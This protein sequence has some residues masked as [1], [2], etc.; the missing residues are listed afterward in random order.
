MYLRGRERSFFFQFL[1]IYEVKRKE[2]N[3][4]II[5]LNDESRISVI[6]LTKHCYSAYS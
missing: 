6:L 4:L 2:T 3:D 5:F 1:N